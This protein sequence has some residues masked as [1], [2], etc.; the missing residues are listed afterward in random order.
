M[1]EDHN[2]ILQERQEK[3]LLDIQKKKL[4]LEILEIEKQIKLEQLR[5]L[6]E[7]PE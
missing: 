6:R 5:R 2:S 1:R 3:K 4:E 7:A